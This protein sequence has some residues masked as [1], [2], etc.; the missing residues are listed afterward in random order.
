MKYQECNKIVKQKAFERAIAGDEHKRSVVDSLDIESMSE[1]G[2]GAPLCPAQSVPRLCLSP[3]FPVHAGAQGGWGSVVPL[4]PV[5]TRCC[6]FTCASGDSTVQSWVWRFRIRASF[7]AVP[8]TLP[9]TVAF[10][11]HGPPV[12]GLSVG[13]LGAQLSLSFIPQMVIGHL[14]GAPVV[15]TGDTAEN[16]TVP[17]LLEL[18]S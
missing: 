18:V 3:P 10:T 2:L 1:S 15:G 11:R 12:S 4:V 8:P 7:P 17:A 16:K 6:S 5:P 13:P 9:S 14:I